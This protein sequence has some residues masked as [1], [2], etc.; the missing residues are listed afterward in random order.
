MPVVAPCLAVAAVGCTDRPQTSELS[1][2]IEAHDYWTFDR[3][4]PMLRV[5]IDILLPDNSRYAIESDEHVTA[6]FRGQSLDLVF[7]D[8]QSAMPHPGYIGDFWIPSDTGE[9]EIV[10]TL[11][12][13]PDDQ[14]VVVGAL[15][16]PFMLEKQDTASASVDYLLRWAPISAYPMNWR[17]GGCAAT[18]EYGQVTNDTG[19]LSFPRNLLRP[20][21]SMTFEVERI[22]GNT[23]SG[24]VFSSTTFTSVLTDYSTV[25]FTP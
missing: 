22:R 13:G 12:R 19:M 16:T 14:A 25:Y 20:G 1:A 15:P 21:C 11:D 9:E 4:Q 2:R 3:Y 17:A 23:M 10:V 7:L 18:D 5:S 24:T 8:R 6:E